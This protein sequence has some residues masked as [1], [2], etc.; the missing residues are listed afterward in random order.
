MGKVIK[1][2]AALVLVGTSTFAQVPQLAQKAPTRFGAVTVGDDKVLLFRGRPLQPSIKGNS[3]LD[4][5]RPFRIGAA[6]IALVTDNGGTACP[7]RYYFVTLSRSGAHT[8]H[9]FG[10][11]NVVVSVKQNG[12]SISLSM[13]GYR[14][15]FEPD[16]ERRKAAHETHFFVF[17]DG[18]V[19]ENGKPAR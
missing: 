14:G 15:P 2:T 19:T 13:H 10:T 3:S 9:S 1:M 17:H 6:D 4:V 5:G 16:V 18:E 12:E 8:T 7:Y 11:Y